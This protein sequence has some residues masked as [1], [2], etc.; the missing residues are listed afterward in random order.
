MKNEQDLLGEIF[1]T[2]KKWKNKYDIIWCDL[3]ETWTIQC[4][5]KNCLASSCNGTSCK[6]CHE[7][8]LDFDKAKTNV[9]DYLTEQEQFIYQK[10][11]RLRELI[12]KSLAM[13][14]YKINWQ[15]LSD[16][17]NFSSFDRQLFPE[18]IKNLKPYKRK[19]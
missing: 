19:K 12:Q 14:H 11:M 3:C 8:I 1:G 15:A 5:N 18:E 2:K 10:S 13:G 4:P 7:D 17:G 6:E 16:D 9:Q